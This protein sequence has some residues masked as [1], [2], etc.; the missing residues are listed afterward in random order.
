[1]KDPIALVSLHSATYGD[2]C[3]VYDGEAQAR[4][5]INHE[6]AS[7]LY[8]MFR[9]KDA[10]KEFVDKLIDRTYLMLPTT[11]LERDGKIYEFKES[12]FLDAPEDCYWWGESEASAQKKD[13]KDVFVKAL[14]DANKDPYAQDQFAISDDLEKK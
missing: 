3:W 7:G 1:M 9:V 13:G 14:D 6:I 2:I 8:V 5:H 11:R 10:K 4:R 12:D